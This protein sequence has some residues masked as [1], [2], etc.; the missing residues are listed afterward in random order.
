MRIEDFD[1]KAIFAEKLMMKHGVATD[2]AEEVFFNRPRIRKVGKGRRA[3]EDVYR[4]L[5]Q[6][7]DGRYLFVIFIYK[8]FDRAALIVSARDMT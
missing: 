7:Y 3:G 2:E 5:G 8:P 4:A 1:W 6:T